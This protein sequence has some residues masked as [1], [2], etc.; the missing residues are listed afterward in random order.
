MQYII[1]GQKTLSNS[2][3]YWITGSALYDPSVTFIFGEDILI[4][5]NPTIIFRER[6]KTIN[7]DYQ[8]NASG[9][10]FILLVFFQNVEIFI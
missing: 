6:N 7:P 4:P 5:G 2:A 8:A 3:P 1:Q 9:N 10:M